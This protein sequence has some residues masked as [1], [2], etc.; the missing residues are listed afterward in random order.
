MSLNLENQ[1]CVVCNAYLFDE[2]DVVYCPQCGAPHHRDCYNSVGKCGMEEFHGTVKEYK[3]PEIPAQPEPT[4]E[5]V[6]KSHICLRCGKT[7]VDNAKFCPYCGSPNSEEFKNI[8]FGN[9]TI[10]DGKTPID[11]GVVAEDVAK[12][13]LLNPLRYV[14]KF[15]SLKGGKKIS[16]NWAAFLV[17]HG[18]FAYRKMYKSSIIASAFKVIANILSIP[19]LMNI[20]SIF[21]SSSLKYSEIVNYFANNPNELQPMAVTLAFVGSLLT[22]IIHIISGIFA[23]SIYKDKVFS[24]VKKIK[25]SSDPE[26]SLRKLGGISTIGFLLAVAAVEFL[27]ELIAI[28]LI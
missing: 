9:F 10:I 11:E 19:L 7:K 15:K 20:Q 28:F 4:E 14:E 12:V 17:P 16:F 1:K 21:G 25:V 18:W 5:A 3:K 22:F 24:S 2:D 26:Q 27:P 6:A 23:D 13:V 8:P